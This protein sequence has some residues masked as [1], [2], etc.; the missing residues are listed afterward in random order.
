MLQVLVTLPGSTDYTSIVI[1]DD[2]SEIMSN[3]DVEHVVTVR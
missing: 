3:G 2:G 1:G